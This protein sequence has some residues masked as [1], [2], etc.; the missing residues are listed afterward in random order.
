MFSI[1]TEIK[2]RR[3]SESWCISM[4]A[5]DVRED[6]SS[7]VLDTYQLYMHRLKHLPASVGAQISRQAAQR[8]CIN[9]V[10]NFSWIFQNF[11]HLPN[12]AEVPAKEMLL[13]WIH[14]NT[15]SHPASAFSYFVYTFFSYA[16]SLLDTSFPSSSCVKN[17]VFV[18][19]WPNQ[20]LVRNNFKYLGSIWQ[21]LC[22][23]LRIF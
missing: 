23:T 8:Y 19:V 6:D 12:F 10:N 9:T 7:P 5:G 14:I 17:S 13:L 2:S 21:T 11:I 3:Q 16:I 18:L 20:I 4:I 22:P 1:L 15:P